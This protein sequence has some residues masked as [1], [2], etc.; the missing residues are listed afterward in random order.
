MK[1]LIQ[2]KIINRVRQFGLQ[3]TL[4]Q[5]LRAVFRGLY[6]FNEDIIFINTKYGEDFHLDPCIKPLTYDVLQRVSNKKILDDTTIQLLSG[7][8]A[9]GSHGVC[10]IIE[11]KFAGYAWIQYNGIY[12]FG[13]SGRMAIPKGYA[14]LKN[15]YV[16]PEFRGHRL[17]RKLNEARL[18]LIPANCVPVVF[19]LPENRVAI[20]NW[21][22]FGFQKALQIKCWRWFK[23]PWHMKLERFAKGEHVY[24]LEKALIESND[25]NHK[26]IKC[27]IRS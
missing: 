19:I 6:H 26:T 5:I 4:L 16:L 25:K 11:G 20:R 1:G 12:R 7:F 23:G 24:R 9:E 3:A 10:A 17:G 27:R 22:I 8:I 18:S 2:D 21:E 15:L 14:V 13:R